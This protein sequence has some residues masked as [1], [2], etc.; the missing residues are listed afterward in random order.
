MELVVMNRKPKPITAA[1][2]DWRSWFRYRG[3]RRRPGVRPHHIMNRTAQMASLLVAVLAAFFSGC[4]H[5]DRPA[6]SG[7]VGNE[8]LFDGLR[9]QDLPRMTAPSLV[10]PP[11]D[12]K[13]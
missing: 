5:R 13:K 2:A 6:A 1:N 3:S 11:S 12:L 4:A 10:P 9:L 7:V 8:F